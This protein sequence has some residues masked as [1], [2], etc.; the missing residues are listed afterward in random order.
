MEY[1]ILKCKFCHHLDCFYREKKKKTRSVGADSCWATQMMK[2]LNKLKLEVI[3][4]KRDNGRLFSFTKNKQLQCRQLTQSNKQIL[5]Y[6][7]NLTKVLNGV[8]RFKGHSSCLLII[9]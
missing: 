4:L 7:V 8:I 3:F 9:S 5:Q 1:F 6:K 2:V